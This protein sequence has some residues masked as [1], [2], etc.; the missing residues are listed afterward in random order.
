MHSL[1]DEAHGFAE[2][3]RRPERGGMFMAAVD[4]A[5]TERLA[6]RTRAG[7]AVTT[8]QL[9]EEFVAEWLGLASVEVTPTARFVADLGVDSFD[10]LEL[11]V[12]AQDRFDAEIGDEALADVVT[13]GDFCRCAIEAIAQR[14]PRLHTA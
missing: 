5:R 7:A 10:L 14:E 3:I 11:A 4:P 8:R 12:E 9:V 13:V 2:T 1:D 6:S